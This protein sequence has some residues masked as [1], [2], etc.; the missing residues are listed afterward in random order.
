MR[1]LRYRLFYFA[2]SLLVIIPGVISLVTVGLRPSIDFTG[3]TLLELRFLTTDSITS[4]QVQQNL[5]DTFV[6]ESIQSSGENQYLLK[7]QEITNDQKNTVV[8]ALQAL[9]PIEEL[10][11]ESVG[12][13]LSGELLRKMYTAVGLVAVLI[14]L[15]V[16]KQFSQLKYGVSAIVAMLHDS[17]V[18]LGVFSML[19]YFYGVEVDVLFVTAVLTTLSFSVHD[20][21]VIYD[22]IRELRRKHPRVSY[23]TVLDSAV[24]ET[25]SRSLN[26]SITIILMLLVLTLFGGDSIRLFALA[27]MIGS[28]T[29]TY[30]SAFTA[31]P[32]LSVWDD[33]SNRKKLLRNKLSGSLK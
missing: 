12:P 17:L 19:G 18:L 22:R 28:I 13:T 16:W 1:F 30:S 15:Y 4:E 26:N 3:G 21:I 2:L 10:R 9:S 23:E 24:L 7:G 14:T 33:M 11:F 31:V 20:T 5:G 27:L 8:A 32:L 25:M 6:A 29:G